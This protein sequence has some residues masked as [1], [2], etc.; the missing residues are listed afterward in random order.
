MSMS[1][2]LTCTTHTLHFL[3]CFHTSEVCAPLL[4]F[5][6]LRM[7]LSLCTRHNHPPLL[8]SPLRNGVFYALACVAVWCVPHIQC[9]LLPP[10]CEYC[11]TA[12]GG[13][14]VGTVCATTTIQQGCGERSGTSM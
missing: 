4:V 6:H 1:A 13:V 3:Y 8:C 11:A 12:W 9:V 2:I 10:H 14:C 5:T 7:A